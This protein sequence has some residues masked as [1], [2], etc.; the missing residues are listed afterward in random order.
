MSI[1][2]VVLGD[3]ESIVREIESY[4]GE[5]IVTRVCS[6]TAE[7][8]AAC[9]TAIADVLLIADAQQ[10]PPM[11]QIEELM[12]NGTAVVYLLENST[13]LS[14]LPDVLQLPVDIA[15]SDLE[16]RI[17]ATVHSLKIPESSPIDDQRSAGKSEPSTQG[18]IVCFWSA[19]GSPGRSTLALNYAVEAAATGK[20]VVLLDA[21]TYAAS[22]SIQLGLMDESASVAQICR[23]MDS[24]STDINRLNAACSLVQVGDTT[25]RV[26]T[27]IPRS[28]R[29]PEVRASALRRAALVFREH[30]DLVVLDIAPHIAMD[31]QL[32]FDTQAPQR[33]AVTVE[34]LRC[35][36]EIFMVVQSDSIGIPRAIRAIDELEENH[37]ELRPKIIFNRVS[38]SSSGRSPKRRLS[39]AWDRFGPMHDVVGFLP[40]DSAVC[41]ASVLAGSPL[42]EIAPKSSL[43]TEI[44]SL[45]GIK[46]TDLPKNRITRRFS[47]SA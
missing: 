44:R 28:S 14:P 23:I 29:W 11:E 7:A 15:M 17:T 1:S 31:E 46:S 37:P 43:R 3:K 6:E 16:E 8:I 32:S 4:Q 35:S 5:L 42:L 38:V 45:A 19:P 21:D 18:K 20:S 10:V 9:L 22:I 34:V 27:G 25:V 36:D 33:N 41:S 2:V 40:N 47:K 30:Y 13:E 24:G 26:G 39:E 12:G